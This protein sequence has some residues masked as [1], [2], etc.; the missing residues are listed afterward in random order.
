M[1]TDLALF[2]QTIIERMNALVAFLAPDGTILFWNV[3]AEQITGYPAL[4]V[5]GKN[6]IW[7]RL[8]PDP[9]Y[10]K[11]ITKMITDVIN[12]QAY[13]RN[14]ETRII[15]E[16]GGEK[17]ISWNTS[18]VRSPG[19][20]ITGYVAVGVDITDKVLNK[21]QLREREELFHGITSAAYNGIILLDEHAI[22]TYWNPAAERIFLYQKQEAKGSTIID[23]L[24]PENARMEWQSVLA[25]TGSHELDARRKDGSLI[26]SELNISKVTIK[27]R[28]HTIIVV[29]DLTEQKRSESQM[30]LL[31]TIV[32]T[33]QEAIVSVSVSGTILSWNKAAEEMTGIP[34][35]DA[36]D[37]PILDLIHLKDGEDRI[38]EAISQ[39]DH[40]VISAILPDRRGMEHDVIISVTPLFGGEGFSLLVRDVTQVK[41][42]QRTMIAYIREATARLK[43]PVE[44]VHE[45]IED[46]LGMFEDDTIDCDSVALRLRVQMTHLAQIAET[47]RELNAALTGEGADIP[48]AYRLFLLE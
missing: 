14:F 3:A 33:S 13:L 38:A 36:L 30:R 24:A 25:K 6:G 37:A 21:R 10:R 41:K 47:I 5:I 9:V 48:E 15:T 29:R 46:I 16:D 2:H 42:A 8:Y 39:S 27:N 18:E 7:K 11:E 31:S 35:E 23:L 20:T 34:E 43:M 45:N 4:E 19:G 28:P 17:Y 44:V 40:A 12:E 22:I 32:Q 1:S 26:P